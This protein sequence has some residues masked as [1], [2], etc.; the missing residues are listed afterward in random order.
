MYVSYSEFFVPPAVSKFTDP[1][2]GNMNLVAEEGENY[3]IGSAFRGNTYVTNINI[4][5]SVTRIC[6]SAFSGCLSIFEIVI[7]TGVTSIGDYAFYG[8]RSLTSLTIPN[9]VTSIGNNTF[10][11]CSDLTSVTIGDGITSIGNN[12]FS[13]CSSLTSVTIPNSVTS[14]GD[15]AFYS[16][17]SNLINVEFLSKTP[18]TIG[19]NVFNL[20]N[21]SFKIYVPF[22]CKTAYIAQDNWSIYSNCIVEKNNI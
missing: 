6:D 2:Y 10:S 5:D 13:H 11:N 1:L 17:P 22:G 18:P 16:Y 20:K 12:A 7:G 21:L 14:I 8:C 9:S 15:S 19:T 4:P 3:E